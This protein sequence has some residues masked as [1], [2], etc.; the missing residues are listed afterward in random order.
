MAFVQHLVKGTFIEDPTNEQLLIPIKVSESLL[1]IK[2]SL[3]KTKDSQTPHASKKEWDQVT[4]KFEVVNKLRHEVKRILDEKNITGAWLKY[5]EIALETGMIRHGVA[6]TAGKRPLRIFFNGEL[7]GAGVLA[8]WHVC[9]TL[10]RIP[11]EWRASS[12]VPSN[13]DSKHSNGKRST[14]LE[15]Q[16]HI[17][18]LN[19]NNWVMGKPDNYNNGDLMDPKSHLYWKNGWGGWADIYLCDAAGA[20]RDYNKQEE[21]HTKIFVGALL[22]GLNIVRKGGCLMVKLYTILEPITISIIAAFS[23]V[24][25]KSFI[26]KPITSKPDNSEVYIVGLGYEPNDKFTNYLMGVLESKYSATE[27][28]N[29]IVENEIYEM[30]KSAQVSLASIQSEHITRNVQAFLDDTKISVVLIDIEKKKEEW[31]RLYPLVPLEASKRIPQLL[32]V[33]QHR[34]NN[35]YIMKFSNAVSR[36]GKKGGANPTEDRNQSSY[37]SPMKLL[38][39]SDDLD[40]L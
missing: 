8:T 36:V 11:F 14:A 34:N 15:D 25:K 3:N 20:V 32:Y 39:S 29:L 28:I 24:F 30:I 26:Y 6:K 13:A 12:L 16:Y 19:P 9:Q 5:Y 18:K 22:A 1:D 33:P 7:P 38:I 35:P 2:T 4:I 31:M 40:S 27:P 10:F 23:A 17:W 37:D 21:E